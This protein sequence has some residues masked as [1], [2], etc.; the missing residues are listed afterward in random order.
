MSEVRNEGD[1]LDSDATSAL[2]ACEGEEAAPASD[3]IDDLDSDSDT[4]KPLVSIPVPLVFFTQLS[5]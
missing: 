5:Y 4:V 3:T 2:D 1:T